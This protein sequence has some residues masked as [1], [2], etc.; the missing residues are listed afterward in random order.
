MIAINPTVV[1]LRP[2]GTGP[3]WLFG[4]IVIFVCIASL[5]ML[6]MVVIFIIEFR[7]RKNRKP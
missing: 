4:A 5:I 6:G 1:L 7:K 2:S 3:D